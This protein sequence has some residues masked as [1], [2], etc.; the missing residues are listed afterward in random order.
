MQTSSYFRHDKASDVCLGSKRQITHKR[1]DSN[2][3]GSGD[4]EA[5]LM[6]QQDTSS[7]FHC[8]RTETRYFGKPCPPATMWIQ[9]TSVY[10]VTRHGGIEQ[11]T[12]KEQMRRQ[13][14]D[15]HLLMEADDKS[16]E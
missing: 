8:W 2:S 5:P 1:P 16:N 15:S 4:I 9:S 11:F 14:N 10:L 7:L 6:G 3:L 13:I 12:D